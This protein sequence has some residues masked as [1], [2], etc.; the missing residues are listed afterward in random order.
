MTEHQSRLSY[1]PPHDSVR[2]GVELWQACE[3]A[4]LDVI[5]P[6]DSQNLMREM[7]VC[8][9]AI[10]MS[11]SRARIMSY[12]TNPVTR[13][14]TVTAGAFVALDEL[15]PGRMMMGIATGDS[16]L[17]SMGRNPAKLQHLR[18][19]I[20]AVKDLCAGDEISW[21]GTTFKPRWAERYRLYI[22]RIL[23]IR[24]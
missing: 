17:W 1:M 7:Y 12:A 8:L 4:G 16:A 11:T 10:A 9:T 24:L 19:Y 5:G 2:Q 22:R 21:D 15:A 20:C 23:G 18:D 3:D 14:L 6:A 13:H